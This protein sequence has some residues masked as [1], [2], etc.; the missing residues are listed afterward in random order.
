MIYTF[1]NFWIYVYIFNQ[2]FSRISVAKH[3]LQSCSYFCLSQAIVFAKWKTSN[4]SGKQWCMLVNTDITFKM[5]FWAG[6]WT[7]YP[8][9]NKKW[10]HL[11]RLGGNHLKISLQFYWHL[12]TLVLVT[13]FGNVLKMISSGHSKKNLLHLTIKFQNFP[14]PLLERVRTLSANADG[15][16]LL[17]TSTRLAIDLHKNSHLF[18]RLFLSKLSCSH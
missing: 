9:N 6:R 8:D 15:W 12:P 5:I 2:D 7:T 10:L 3:L 16:T 17:L 4:L 14:C 13:G 11:T 18:V 1:F